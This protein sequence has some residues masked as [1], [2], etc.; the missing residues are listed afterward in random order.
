MRRTKEEAEHT[1]QQLLRAARDII[2]EKGYEALRL[3]DVASRIGMT[4]GAVYWH[5]GSKTELLIALFKDRIDPFFEFIEQIMNEPLT[6]L[7][8]LE[9]FLV[10][11]IERL[12]RDNE[13]LVNQR[14]YFQDFQIKQEIPEIDKYFK[15]RTKMFFQN[16]IALMQ[17]G[18]DEGEIRPLDP[19]AMSSILAAFFAGY[20]EIYI[21]KKVEDMYLVDP[22]ILVDVFFKG[23]KAKK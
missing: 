22:S 2:C 16:F 3:S 18:I 13:F 20:G 8:K 5:F 7:Q 10:G 4:R 11:F 1:R 17:Q 15:K 23:I 9:K 14:L 6:A 21:K 19:K 12:R